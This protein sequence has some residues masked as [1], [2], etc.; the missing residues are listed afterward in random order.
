MWQT[1]LSW[2]NRTAEDA[3]SRAR[4]G[5]QAVGGERD[6]ER[7]VEQSVETEVRNVRKALKGKE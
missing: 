4:L 2:L 6:F 7:E 3:E 1:Y 5:L